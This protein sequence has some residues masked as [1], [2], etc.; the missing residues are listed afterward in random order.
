MWKLIFS[1]MVLL[2][3]WGISVEAQQVPILTCVYASWASY[4]KLPGRV[5]GDE[6][7]AQICTHA[8]YLYASMVVSFTVIRRSWS[9]DRLHLN[10][11]PLMTIILLSCY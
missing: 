7:P 1:L 3:K 2:L 8:V 9:V 10:D 4:R 6:L 5:M 11:F